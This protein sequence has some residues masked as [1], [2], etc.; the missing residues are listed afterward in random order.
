MGGGRSDT[1][2]QERDGLR[3]PNFD[4]KSQFDA[5][6]AKLERIIGLL[7]PKKIEAVIPD[8]VV[9]KVKKV[10]TPKVKKTAKKTSV[11]K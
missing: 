6:N 2:R 10:K 1:S 11:K 4:Q 9:E 3:A 5:I 7:E 8:I